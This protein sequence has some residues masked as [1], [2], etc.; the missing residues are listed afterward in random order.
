MDVQ[1]VEEESEKVVVLMQYNGGGCDSASKSLRDI[2]VLNHSVCKWLDDQEDNA[3]SVLE[4]MFIQQAYIKI[5]YHEMLHKKSASR[6][7]L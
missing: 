7:L 3:H 5:I 2:E 4:Q 6:P 1:I